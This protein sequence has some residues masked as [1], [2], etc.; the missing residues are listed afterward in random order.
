M[1][2]DSDLLTGAR[3]RVQ[4]LETEADGLPA[5]IAEARRDGDTSAWLRLTAREDELPGLISDARSAVVAAE[6][7]TAWRQVE[8]AAAEADQLTAAADQAAINE[9]TARTA[10]TRTAPGTAERD[11]AEAALA[12]ARR[13]AVEARTEAGTASRHVQQLLIDVEALEARYRDAAGE[14]PAR[15]DGIRARPR[16][17]TSGIYLEHPTTGIREFIAPD[18]VP[19]RWAAWALRNADH[20]Y[21]PKTETD[22]R[23]ALWQDLD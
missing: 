8:A 9:T 16:R 2:R 4:E 11:D 19:P 3:R 17:T 7:E 12:R 10:L 23:P 6:L 5:L 1:S 13:D 18:T 21:Q 15:G 22:R 20:I 14:P